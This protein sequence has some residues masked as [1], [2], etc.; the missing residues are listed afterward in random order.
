MRRILVVD[1][2]RSILDLVAKAMER[3]GYECATAECAE[4]ARKVLEGQSFDLIMSDVIMPGESGLDFLRYVMETFPDTATLLISVMDD[5]QVVQEALELGVYGYIVKPF[6]I[7]A[8]QID[9]ESALR[10]RDL[11]VANRRYREDLEDRVAARTR[12]LRKQQEEYARLVKTLPCVIYTGNPDWTVRFASDRIQEICGY[13]PDRFVAGRMRWRELILEEDLPIIKTAVKEALQGDGSFIREYRIRDAQGHVRWIQDRGQIV[14]NADGSI[15]HVSG[16]IFDIT[17]Q[18]MAEEALERARREWEHTFDAVPDLIAVMDTERRIRNVN[19]AFRERVGESNGNLLDEPC[20]KILHG[21]ER[22]CNDCCLRED[23]ERGSACEKE[24]Y[25]DKLGAYFHS[26]GAP[27]FDDLNNLTG[28]VIVLRDI[29]EQKK[30]EEALQQ[31]HQELG[32][33]FSAIS[34]ILIGLDAERRILRWNKAAEEIFALSSEEVTGRALDELGIDWQWDRV[35]QALD[36]CQA[37]KKAQRV[38]DLRYTRADGQPGFLGLNIQGVDLGGE[39]GTGFLIMG[40]EITRRKIM[41]SQ[42]AQAQKLES[43]GQ[44]AAG[45][46]HEINTPTQFIGDNIRFLQDAFNDLEELIGKYRNLM[47][48]ARELEVLREAAASVME[49]EESL[50]VEYL[51]EEIPQAISQSLDG[52]QRVARIVL[53]MKEFS[54][55]G[56]EEKVLLDINHALENTLTVA[57]NEW[58]YVADVVTDFDPSLPPVPCIPAELNQVFLNIIVNAA[59]AI[60]DALG[61]GAEDKGTITITTRHRD[62]VCEVRISDTGTGI[63]KEI[64]HRI[65]DPFFTTKEVGKGT[66]QGLAISHSV[67]VEKHGGK[68]TFETEEGRGTTFIIQLPVE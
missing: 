30:A 47:E 26:I 12:E 22:A 62:D 17:G 36:R 35:E 5:S 40:A 23:D 50:D 7:R 56:Q 18:K 33:L 11:E 46:A 21:L 6:N 2:Q 14:K 1:D 55:P 54:H 28:H 43:I 63:P 44:L 66:G 13:P 27:V 53:A 60:K 45:I 49:E 48:K 41:E 64:R 31:A 59:H 58:K 25:I 38:D 61:D 32:Q 29:T 4:K 68:L 52:V 3:L 65:F 24:V 57:R 42:L 51:L 37:K 67:I 39:R 16:V 8:I 20:Y 10:R 19:R 15:D 34:S 9:V